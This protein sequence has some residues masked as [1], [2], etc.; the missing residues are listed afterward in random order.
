MSNAKPFSRRRVLLT[1]GMAT[2]AAL[3]SRG[4]VGAPAG[5]QL[6]PEDPQAQA[7]GYVHDAG[8]VD[9]A[10]WPKIETPAGQ[11]CS[12]CA[13]WQGGDAEWGGCGIFPGKQVA[14]AGWC[15]AW[16]PKG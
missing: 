8:T 14:A 12:N 7:L 5:Q 4:A 6:S 15:N 9:P 13:L 3:L 2:A 10:K 11:K 16:V 1:G